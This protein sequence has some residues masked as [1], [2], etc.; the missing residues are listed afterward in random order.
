MVIGEGQDT[1]ESWAHD[2]QAQVEMSAM[3]WR[4]SPGSPI[5]SA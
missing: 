1:R 5:R 3:C 2:T 4:M